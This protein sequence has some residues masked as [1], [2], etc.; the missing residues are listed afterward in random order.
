MTDLTSTL[1]PQDS[2]IAQQGQV[3]SFVFDYQNEAGVVSQSKI[4]S[5]SA[6]VIQAGTINTTINIGGLN[7]LIDGANGRIIVNDGTVDRVLI[8]KLVGGF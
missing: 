8:G 4:K 5:L 1:M 2:P 7:V 6:D 3:T